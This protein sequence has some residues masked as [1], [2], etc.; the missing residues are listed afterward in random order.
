MEIIVA[1]LHYGNERARE[2]Q[3]E[4]PRE[5]LGDARAIS[6]SRSRDAR[7]LTR[8]MRVLAAPR[9]EFLISLHP[10]PDGSPRYT[11]ENGRPRR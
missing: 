10:L 1:G 3:E 11:P 8:F 5:R 4:T 9:I 6:D 7:M 2:P